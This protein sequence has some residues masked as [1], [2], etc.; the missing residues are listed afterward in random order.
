M[1]FARRVA[2]D[3]IA[4]DDWDYAQSFVASVSGRA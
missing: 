1:K 2:G 4:G 3:R